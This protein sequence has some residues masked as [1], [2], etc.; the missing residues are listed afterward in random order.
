MAR[1]CNLCK[2]LT[3][4][5]SRR[6]REVGRRV[7]LAA[8][9]D[10]CLQ[11]VGNLRPHEKPEAPTWNCFESAGVENLSSPVGGPGP[12]GPL[13]TGRRHVRAK[14]DFKRRCR[15]GS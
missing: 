8:L 5:L 1:V 15:R 2:T 13:E 6:E 11:V 4:T 7:A 10:S 12:V 14:S 3:L 9:N